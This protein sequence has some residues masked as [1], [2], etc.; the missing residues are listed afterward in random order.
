MRQYP[1]NRWVAGSKKKE[2]SRCGFDFLDSEMAVE[3]RTGL[4]VCLKCYD[5]P[6]PQDVFKSRGSI[7]TGTPRAVPATEPGATVHNEES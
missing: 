2:C 7:G 5:P 3:E 1:L 6:H 4:L